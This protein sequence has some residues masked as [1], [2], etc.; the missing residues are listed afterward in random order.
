MDPSLYSTFEKVELLHWWFCGRRLIVKEI[1]ENLELPNSASI[2]EVGCGTG[3]NIPMLQ[4]FGCVKAI[5]TSSLG[6]EIAKKRTGLSVLDGSLP[7]NLN[8]D[9]ESFDLVVLL[10]VLEHVEDDVGS[11]AEIW[12]AIKPGGVLI[13]TVPA[14]QFLWSRHDELNHHFRRYD[15][16]TL[17]RL[18][19]SQSFNIEKASYFN[20]ILFPLAL[21]QRLW[22]K[23]YPP[24]DAG[25]N[26]PDNMVNSFLLR[27]FGLER[28]WLRYMSIPFGLSLIV[29]ARKN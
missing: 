6:R 24:A 26:V 2:L 16:S 18:L 21:L 8:V 20:S 15:K 3:G 19:S 10:D 11:V 23:I 27:I 12:K 9:R 14:F 28:Y 29:V 13:M 7:F 4:Q 17:V 1:L 5:E 22:Q 25:I